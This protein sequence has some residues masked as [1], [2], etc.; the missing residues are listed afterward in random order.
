MRKNTKL[1]IIS[2]F[3]FT[4][5]FIMAAPKQPTVEFVKEPYTAEFEQ[6]S[7][8]LYYVSSDTN[9]QIFMV[10][11]DINNVDT[12]KAISG[13]AY[14][15]VPNGTYYV[16]AKDNNGNVSEP[17]TISVTNSCSN[18]S[19]V[20]A[21]GTGKA[22]RCFMV[23]SNQEESE[24]TS[25]PLVICATNYY[26]DQAATAIS[27]N[28]CERKSFTGYNLNYRYCKKSYTYKCAKSSASYNLKLSNLALSTG[29]LTPNFS[30]TNYTYSAT[31]TES[32]VNV[33]A[34][35]QDSSASFVTDFGPRTVNLNYGL[36]TILVKTQV[37][38]GGSLTYTIKVTRTDTRKTN[39][40]LSTLSIKEA[41]LSP[42]F[43][44]NVVNYSAKVGEDVSEVTIDASLE[45]S[46]ASFVKDFGP[47]KVTLNKGTNKVLVK[48]RSES[49][50]IRVYTITIQR[51]ENTETIDPNNGLVIDPTKALLKN[52]ILSDGTITFDPNLFDYN[53]VVD[54]NTSNITVTAEKND[55]TDIVTITGGENLEVG[56]INIITVDVSTGNGS[57]TNTYTIYVERREENIAISSDS[58]LRDLIIKDY[59]IKFDAK[60]TQYEVT[61]KEGVTSLD[62]EAKTNSDKA[63]YTVEGNENLTNGSEIKIR[64]TAE[65]NSYTDYFIRVSAKRRGGNVFLTIFVILLIILVLAY[66]VLRAMG[67]K[68]VL[69]FEAIKD[70]FKKRFAKK[71]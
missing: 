39:N 9:T 35:L 4:P 63:T 32:S 46:S 33:I 1:L 19:V 15:T 22:E 38:T 70:W 34:T 5:G 47:R 51:G 66:L 50:R 45:D 60:T 18:T 12:Y 58:L 11:Q 56:G 29:S 20:N 26:L 7:Q 67:Y 21:S 44:S 6:D 53:V 71:D 55:E 59:K 69:N 27:V 14:I 2:L 24:T 41:T 49:G 8:D 16:W 23:T 25:E 36:N 17:T 10:G 30:A 64:V 13:N 28:D 62:I 42:S 65:D 48:V 54:Y 52:L 43:K 40:N 68:I 61:L 31:T 57:S 3:A 37:P